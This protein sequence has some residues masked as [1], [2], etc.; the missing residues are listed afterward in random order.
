MGRNNPIQ[1]NTNYNIFNPLNGGEFLSWFS[2]RQ[3]YLGAV[4]S[5]YDDLQT[6]PQ[7]GLWPVSFLLG[8]FGGTGPYLRNLQNVYL[9]SVPRIWKS[10]P[11]ISNW[12]ALPYTCIGY[13]VLRNSISPGWGRVQV[14]CSYTRWKRCVPLLGFV[15]V[16]PS[17][18]FLPR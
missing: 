8:G 1:L 16:K 2:Q 12:S 9:L 10:Q 15:T 7:N 13:N 18:L 17:R 5:F 14:S 3:R 6:H 4:F 11:W